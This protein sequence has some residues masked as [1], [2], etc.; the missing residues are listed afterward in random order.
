MVIYLCVCAYMWVCEGGGVVIV[1][2]VWKIFVGDVV[3]CSSEN[4]I[5]DETELR[6]QLIELKFSCSFEEVVADSVTN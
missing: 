3:E 1:V 4:A 5:S 6:L 2:G